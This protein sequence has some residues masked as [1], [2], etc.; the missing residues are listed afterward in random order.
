MLRYS[1]TS[2]KGQDEIIILSLSEQQLNKRVLGLALSS[3]QLNA[4][5]LSTA[6]SGSNIG[7][8]EFKAFV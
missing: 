3:P 1:I 4:E 5:T 6:T 2:L 7:V 8:L